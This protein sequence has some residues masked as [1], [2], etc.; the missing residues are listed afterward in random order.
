MKSGFSKKTRTL[1]KKTFNHSFISIFALTEAV[2]LTGGKQRLYDRL[3]LFAASH[4]LFNRRRFTCQQK[5]HWRALLPREKMTSSS[6]FH[7]RHHLF[8]LPASFL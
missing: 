3:N 4:C 5:E 2:A 7:K 6:F 8:T 1:N